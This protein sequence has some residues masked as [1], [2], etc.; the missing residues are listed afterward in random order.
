MG[1]FWNITSRIYAKYHVQIILLFVY[2]TTHKRFV[3]FTC[4]YFKLSWN[5]TAL[6]QSNCRNFS[7]RFS[8]FPRRHPEHNSICKFQANILKRSRNTRIYRAFPLMW[9]ELRL[10]IVTKERVHIRKDFNSHRTHSI[11]PGENERTSSWPQV[12]LSDTISKAD[13][14]DTW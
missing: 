10:F 6:S 13:K 3:I 11:C 4:R 1:Q 7:C 12:C 8:Q 9:Q 5:T 14:A 2:N